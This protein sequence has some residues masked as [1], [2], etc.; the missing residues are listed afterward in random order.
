MSI[1]EAIYERISDIVAEVF[2]DARVYS[3]GS[4][5]NN[6]PAHYVPYRRVSNLHS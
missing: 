2:P 4:H 1:R 3:H 6:P 5:P